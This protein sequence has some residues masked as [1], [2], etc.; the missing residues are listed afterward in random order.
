MRILKTIFKGIDFLVGLIPRVGAMKIRI[1]SES[2]NR[3]LTIK[4]LSDSNWIKEITFHLKKNFKSRMKKRPY[5]SDMIKEWISA[6]PE[7][8][9]VF[10]RRKMITWPINSEI[11]VSTVKMLPLKTDSILATKDNF[12]PFLVKG[13]DLES[14]FNTAK[15]IWVGD[16]TS[17]R[18]E[19]MSLFAIVKRKLQPLKIPVYFRTANDKLRYIL[20]E[21]YGAK[22][23]NPTGAD[24]DGDTI[25]VIK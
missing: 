22:V 13:S 10:V 12:D 4:D 2:P 20:F 11:V 19:L 14:D 16:A 18:Q 5:T 7:T 1:D 24:A 8:L 17:S 15:A 25:L 9:I 6:N 3:E 23:L 21:R